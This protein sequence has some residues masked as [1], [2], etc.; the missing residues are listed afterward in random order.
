[1]EV[2]VLFNTQKNALFNYSIVWI[3]GDKDEKVESFMRDIVEYL[4][5]IRKSI[6]S[7]FV[8]SCYQNP[9]FQIEPNPNANQVFNEIISNLSKKTM[10]LSS[11]RLQL[12]QLNLMGSIRKR[13]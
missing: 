8:L 9:A 13:D 2:P 11:S 12:Q 4:Q 6:N 1:V 7:R 3:L 10:T 5:T